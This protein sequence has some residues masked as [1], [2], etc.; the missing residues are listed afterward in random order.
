M[1]TF[2]MIY[3]NKSKR[4]LEKYQENNDAKNAFD[5]WFLDCNNN[6][7]FKN[8]KDHTIFYYTGSS[9]KEERKGGI[10]RYDNRY[11]ILMIENYPIYFKTCFENQ[12]DVLIENSNIIKWDCQK[13]RYV[14]LPNNDNLF[15]EFDFK[16]PISLEVVIPKQEVLLRSNREFVTYLSHKD[17]NH[18]DLVIQHLK[19]KRFYKNCKHCKNDS[20]I[21]ISRMIDDNRFFCPICK[22]I[23]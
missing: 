18:P 4:L 10:I 15:K 17:Q 21:S 1:K 6:I 3:E 9:I 5:N 19:F 16:I 7:A 22:R 2:L 11:K 8:L 12:G 23:N 13:N 20:E 14:I